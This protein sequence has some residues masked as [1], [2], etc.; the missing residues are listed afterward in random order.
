MPRWVIVDGMKIGLEDTGGPGPSIVLCH[1]GSC[2]RRA[3]ERQL[4]GGLA[5]RFRL[6]ALDLPGH[7]DSDPSSTPDS[8]YTLP[9]YARVLVEVARALD[10]ERSVFVGWSLGGHVVLH[11]SV[12]L[13]KALGFFVFGAAPVGK[14]PAL[15]RM[16]V[17]DP[18]LAAGYRAESS[19]AEIRA[20]VARF[21]RPRFDAPELFCDDFRR[22]DPRTRD[23]LAASIARLDFEDEFALLRRMPAPLA[24]VHGTE[25]AIL[26]G[27]YFSEF[28]LKGLWRGGVQLLRGAGHASHW[29]EPGAFDALLS[30]FAQERV[31]PDLA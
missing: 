26:N 2:S 23:A 12:E 13:P 25:D 31:R 9:G 20:L 5:R 28:P 21:F 24:I 3:F 15:D 19:D 6:V 1:G 14:P 7:G 4:R 29:E 8:T 11:A 30:E 10:L 16:H 18:A 22:S 27:A 17:Q